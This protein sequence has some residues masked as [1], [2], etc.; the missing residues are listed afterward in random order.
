[1]FGLV[2]TLGKKLWDLHQAGVDTAILDS[3]HKGLKSFH[4]EV[5]GH[6][7]A[8]GLHLKQ[9]DE[10]IADESTEEAK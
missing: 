1:M 7:K 4:H 5:D 8:H 10:G 9:T 3:L 6:H 2:F